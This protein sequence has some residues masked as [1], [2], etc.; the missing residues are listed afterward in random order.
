MGEELRL[1]APGQG[2]D[3]KPAG[4]GVWRTPDHLLEE[5]RLP[6][7]ATEAAGSGTFRES[8]AAASGTSHPQASISDTWQRPAEFQRPASE[9]HSEY[10]VTVDDIRQLISASLAP[11]RR[12]SF[13][14]SSPAYRLASSQAP[15]ETALR[16]FGRALESELSSSASLAGH[17]TQVDHGGGPQGSELELPPGR[18]LFLSVSIVQA[19]ASDSGTFI[20]MMDK[21]GD[22]GVLRQFIR[23]LGGNLRL[24]RQ[25]HQDMSLSLYLPLAG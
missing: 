19:T 17:A 11:G 13:A 21:K 14:S 20:R 2:D 3:Q 24:D 5:E 4:S 1:S 12:L 10:R 8:E 25:G 7:G 23:S 18:Y 9:S 6:P 22:H 15:A 16:S